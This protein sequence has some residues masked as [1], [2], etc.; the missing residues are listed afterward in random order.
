MVFI[1]LIKQLI[2]LSV[3]CIENAHCNFPK[4]KVTLKCFL[5]S[6]KSISL[7][8]DDT[9]L[10]KKDILYMAKGKQ[11]DTLR[12]K[13]EYHNKCKC[14]FC[15]KGNCKQCRQIICFICILSNMMQAECMQVWVCHVLLDFISF[16]PI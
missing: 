16:S 2:S 11:I 12:T 8:A 7:F 3:K 6:I 1:F 15:L 13:H 4:P 5:L 14:M 10:Y 9:L